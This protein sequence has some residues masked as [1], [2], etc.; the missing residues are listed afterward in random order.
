MKRLVD[1]GVAKTKSGVTTLAEVGRV[2][3][4]EMIDGA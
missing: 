4:S 2:T 3:V 1:D